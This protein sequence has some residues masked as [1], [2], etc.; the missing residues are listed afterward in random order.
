M[1]LTMNIAKRPYSVQYCIGFR[2][3]VKE[4]FGQNAL[5]IFH[6]D[7]CWEFYSTIICPPQV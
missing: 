2:T 1:G 5:S 3:T 7:P 4:D 6:K